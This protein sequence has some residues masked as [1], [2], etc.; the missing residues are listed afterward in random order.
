M[1]R[2]TSRPPTGAQPNPIVFVAVR[3]GCARGSSGGLEAWTRGDV[4]TSRRR[5]VE[6]WRRRDLGPGRAPPDAG[7]VPQPRSLGQQSRG[8]ARTRRGAPAVPHPAG[9]SP[10][11]RPE[12][13]RAGGRRPNSAEGSRTPCPRA[14]SSGSG[15]RRSS[16]RSRRSRPHGSPGPP[17]ARC[18]LPRTRSRPRSRRR[19]VAQG[20]SIRAAEVPDRVV[21]LLRV[22]PTPVDLG[23]PGR[24]D[25]ARAPTGRAAAERAHARGSRLVVRLAALHPEATALTPTQLPEEL[26][27]PVLRRD[28]TPAGDF[29]AVAPAPSPE[30]LRGALCEERGN[31]SRPGS[32]PQ[33]GVPLARAVGNRPRHVPDGTKVRIREP[34]PGATPSG[35]TPS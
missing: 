33:A 20:P 21:P 29:G 2:S 1:A 25:A 11:S 30:R 14:D 26:S 9:G 31:A 3:V 22:A 5:G 6:A 35:A 32:R 27:G 19:R 17:G 7:P 28:A 4:E 24:A 16:R 12:P 10:A 13:D 18:T 34:F 8:I 15:R 23:A